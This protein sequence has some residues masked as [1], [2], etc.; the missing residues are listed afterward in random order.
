[1]DE[2]Q[3]GASPV[4]GSGSTPPTDNSNAMNTETA[5]NPVSTQLGNPS[6]EGSMPTE[7]VVQPPVNNAPVAGQVMPETLAKPPQKKIF[8]VLVGGVVLLL[9][10]AVLVLAIL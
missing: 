3:T 10:L 8:L 4:P 9:A 6:P 7:S 5:N 2:Q 1:M